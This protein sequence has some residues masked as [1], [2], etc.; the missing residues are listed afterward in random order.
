MPQAAF[1]QALDGLEMTVDDA[2]TRRAA[3]EASILAH[4]ATAARIRAVVRMT[5]DSVVPPPPSVSAA[6]LELQIAALAQERRWN[7]SCQCGGGARIFL[8]WSR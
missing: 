7:H 1:S 3:R 5:H 4:Q 2:E 6:Q 8:D